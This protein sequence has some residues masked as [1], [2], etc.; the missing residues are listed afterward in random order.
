MLTVMKFLCIL[1]WNF[2]TKASIESCTIR[3]NHMCQY[4]LRDSSVEKDL[5]VLVDNRSSVSQ[6]YALVAKKS[7]EILK[8][9]KRSMAIRTREVILPLYSALFR[10]HLEYCIQFLASQYKKK[11]GISWKESSGGPQR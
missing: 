1:V 7:S 8:C 4:R 2:L 6:Q 9:I 5:G 10:P 3:N 11:T